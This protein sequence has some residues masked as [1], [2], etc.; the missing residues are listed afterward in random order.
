MSSDMSIQMKHTMFHS[1]RL[2]SDS[3]VDKP[4]VSAG[5]PVIHMKAWASSL[6][7]RPVPAAWTCLI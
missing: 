5:R 4:F 7:D 2:G 1:W 6:Q 3:R